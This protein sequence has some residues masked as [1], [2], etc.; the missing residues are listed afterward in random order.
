MRMAAFVVSLVL[1]ACGRVVDLGDGGG[2]GSAPT[3]GGSTVGMASCAERGCPA[4]WK[5][6][7]V[8]L[9][10]ELCTSEVE[11]LA[12]SSCPPASC[13][14]QPPNGGADGGSVVADA[15]QITPDS[16]AGS[17]SV[18]CGEEECVSGQ[19]CC[20]VTI[21]AKTCAT[22]LQCVWGGCPPAPCD[23]HSD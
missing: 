20:I 6:C 12:T 1:V 22:G 7:T 13:E 10:P 15:G 18:G 2:S 23:P 5:C 21:D 16:D 11:C 8:T 4:G 17:G 9:D 3:N 19:D 14:P